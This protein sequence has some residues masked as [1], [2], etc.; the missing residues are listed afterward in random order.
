MHDPAAMMAM[1]VQAAAQQL[2]PARY[3]ETVQSEGHISMPDSVRL[4]YKLFMPREAGRWPVIL[5]R[6]PYTGNDMMNNAIYGP[7]FSKYGYA[8]VN[9][10]V[11][12]C[13]QS[14]GD[15]LPMENEKADG[16]A[17]IDWIAEQPWCDGNIGTMGESYL[18]HTQWCVADYHHPMLKTMY[19]GVYGVR[20]YHFFYRR[21][22]FREE[23][24]TT[25]AAQMMG[26]HRRQFIVPPQLSELQRKAYAVAPQVHLGEAMIGE[27][28]DWYEKWVTST[29]ETDPYWSEGFWHELRQVTDQVNVP[30]HFQGGWF[31]I[32]LRMELE[33]YRRLP[34]AIR[35]Q[36]RFVIEPYSHSGS[37]GGC[38]DYPDADRLGMFQVKGALEW[39]D[40]QLKGM[41]YPHPLGVVEGYVVR[42][43]S[44]RV[45]TDDIPEGERHTWYLG[46]GT[47]SPR[48][49]TCA[50][51]LSY[52]YDPLNPVETRGGNLLTNNR[53]P[54]GPPECSTEQLPAGAREDVLSFVSD[55][56][57]E[58]VCITGKIEAHLFV[59]S[60]VPATAYTIKV[61]EVLEDGRSVN[62]QDDISDIRWLDEN[63]IR[64]YEPG[65][66][67]ELSWELLDTCWKLHK[68][69]KLRVDVSSSNFPAYH[70]HPNTTEC[71]AE[72]TETAI[73]NQTIFVGG[74][75]PSRIIIPVS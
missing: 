66:V 12:G 1:A 35:E 38:L 33:S 43:G 21:G 57:E 74:Q 70:V 27:H 16:R 20:P 64:D 7:L 58:D 34:K 31:D 65:T 73:A 2:P 3:E 55:V 40:Y 48:E 37:T 60:D 42:D 51:E 26:N 9:V 68:G 53:D 39:F 6:N 44:W 17:V 4:H 32:F 30:I 46:A 22:M 41:D 5:M 50:A 19:I 15:F 71:W 62:I 8:Y 23:L 54:F 67:R 72:T 24:A 25:W 56:L 52:V 29:R 28:L 69:S 18:A 49:T 63:T 45:W 59:S 75:Y 13:L 11:R 61:M 36:S 10:S 47:L 14:E